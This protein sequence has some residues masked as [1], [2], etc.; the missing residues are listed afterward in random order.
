M[1]R[2]RQQ[3]RPIFPGTAQLRKPFFEFV[4][5]RARYGLHRAQG[6]L[7]VAIA[8]SLLLLPVQILNDGIHYEVVDRTIRL[9][10]Q[11]DEPLY[12]PLLHL[13]LWYVD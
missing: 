7:P 4:I 2:G 9:L 3:W 11:L 10:S 8:S 6:R 12:W 5:R 13:R 1:S